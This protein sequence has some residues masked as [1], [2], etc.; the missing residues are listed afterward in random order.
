MRMGAPIG[1]AMVIAAT[2]LH[3]AT[4]AKPPSCG[5]ASVL[6]A[7]SLRRG[8]R[9][10]QQEPKRREWGTP[11]RMATTSDVCSDTPPFNTL[12][13]ALP[14]NLAGNRVAI[15]RHWTLGEL[16]P[17]TR[18][19]AADVQ[20]DADQVQT[21]AA[22]A[23]GTYWLYANGGA[24]KWVKVG[25]AALADQANTVLAPGHGMLVTKRSIGTPSPPTMRNCSSLEIAAS[26]S[27]CKATCTATPYPTSRLCRC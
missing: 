11:A 12:A 7:I 6:A 25:D 24:P 20:T 21:T 4:I 14:A 15:H 8:C 17:V 23:T 19:F 10:K 13:G 27:R 9:Q 26:S 2:P 5:A 3:Q 22:A 1:T 18:F 16:F